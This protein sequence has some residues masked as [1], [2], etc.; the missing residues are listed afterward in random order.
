MELWAG[1]ALSPQSLTNQCG[2]LENKN[3][4]SNADRG[5]LAW[6]AKTRSGSLRC[7][8]KESAVCLAVA[9]ELAMMSMRPEPLR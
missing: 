6:E 4:E 1:K 3:A 9:E 7:C 2:I 8:E 5:G